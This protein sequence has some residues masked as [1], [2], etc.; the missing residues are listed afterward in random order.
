MLVDLLAVDR[1]DAVFVIEGRPLYDAGLQARIGRFWPLVCEFDLAGRAITC[2]V[3]SCV[4]V[5]VSA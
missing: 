1:N 2:T 3:T 4:I 5:A